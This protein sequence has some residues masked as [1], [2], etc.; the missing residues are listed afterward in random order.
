VVDGALV[1]LTV[2][3]SI[4]A[5]ADQVN[6]A[7]VTAADGPLKGI[8]RCTSEPVVSQ[9]VIG[10]PAS[11]LFDT[12]LTRAVGSTVKVLGWYDNECGHAPADGRPGRARRPHHPGPLRR[13]DGRAAGI[14]RLDRR[15]A[16]RT[17]LPARQPWEHGVT[18]LMNRQ[19][20]EG[21]AR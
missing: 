20:R 5:T 6:E 9:D 10:E 12:G 3:L 7:F 14:P 15:A 16:G 4:P 13:V 2:R 1:D 19:E 21:A 8:L 18:P 17:A 11:C